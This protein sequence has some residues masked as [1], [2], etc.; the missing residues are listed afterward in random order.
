VL[1]LYRR[2]W[3]ATGQGQII[4]IVLSVSIAAV[5]AVTLKYQKD[6]VNGL[7][8]SMG[9]DALLL[10]GA[11]F[12]GVLALSS[13]LKFISGYRSSILS[14]SVI[15]RLRAIIYHE[16]AD[17]SILDETVVQRLRTQIYGEH[18]DE[19]ESK[20][21]KSVE[22]GTLVTMITAEAEEVGKFA[23]EAIATPLMQFG[24]LFSVIVYIASSQPVLGLFLAA[25]VLPQ[26][27]IVFRI[28]RY[29]NA[30][31]AE[32]VKILRRATNR[33]VSEDM[34]Q[35][36]QAILSDF[37]VIYE[38]RRKIYFLKLSSKFALNLL[39]GLGTVGVLMLG[40]WLVLEEQT[41]IGTVVAALTGMTRISQPWRE[42][43]AF[44]RN[45]SSIVVKWQ[46]LISALLK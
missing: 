7:T 41:D 44:Y 35:L 33:I 29:I 15:R 39:N 12:L 2:I 34:K 11:E 40:G 18:V 19:R 4:L 46:L 14:E 13:G 6:I 24:T 42:L 27:A 16:S 5:A 9:R 37:D 45:L 32:R 31:V 17:S 43:I 36:E 25:I 22:Q 30:R 3:R 10:L 21:D 23:G 8:E 38:A 20:E 1:E 26:A 28:Q